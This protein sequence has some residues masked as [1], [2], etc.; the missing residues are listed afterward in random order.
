[1]SSPR[2][3][4]V[5]IGAARSGTNMLRDVLCR[6]PGHGTWPCD[7][8]NLI[9]RHGN[10]THPN[11]ELQVEHARPEVRSYIRDAFSR[12]ARSRGYDRVVEKTCA[13]SLR[14]P[15]VARVL[16]EARFIFLVRDGRDVVSSAMK[17]WVAPFDLG[18]TLAKARYAPITDVPFYG[19]RLIRNRVFRWGHAEHRVRS[20]GPRFEGMDALLQERSLAEVCATQ[21]VRSVNRAA[22]ALDG[23]PQER[24]RRVRYEDFVSAPSD[25]LAP[26]L[27]LLEIAPGASEV[28]SAVAGVGADSIGKWRSQ[29]SAP[30][31]ER[32]GSILE[33]TL[34]RHG[35]A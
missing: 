17:R 25:S 15:F 6:L 12:L 7:E 22:E 34:A 20:W 18:Y 13:N 3:P 23:L 21:W 19:L 33:A 28:A 26:L 31:Q 10:R 2:P 5:L 29:L 30:D 32:I 9:W 35:Y 11:D 8:I 14:V 27:E 16:P 1:M 24:V 4:V